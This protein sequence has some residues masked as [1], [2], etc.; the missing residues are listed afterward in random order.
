[1]EFF[2]H[3]GSYQLCPIEKLSFIPRNSLKK[4]NIEL[5]NEPN[6]TKVGLY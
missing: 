4:Q 2:T 1:M 5:V 6:D 3:E